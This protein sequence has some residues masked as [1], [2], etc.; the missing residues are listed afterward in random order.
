L[1]D[2]LTF[3]QMEQHVGSVFH[4]DAGGGQTVDLK[5]VRA[6][7]VMESEAARLPRQPFSLFFSGPRESYLPQ[8]IYRLQHDGFA[9]PMDI[10]LV[11]VES[12]AGGFLYEA[13]FT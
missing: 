5:L 13:V 10:F 4:V 6:G 7:K 3:E 11:P 9:E 2:H 12:N 1:L 8:R